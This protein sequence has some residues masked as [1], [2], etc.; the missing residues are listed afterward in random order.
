MLLWNGENNQ[1]FRLQ[2]AADESNVV[3][4]PRGGFQAEPPAQDK[5]GFVYAKHSNSTLQFWTWDDFAGAE[6]GKKRFRLVGNTT[7]DG[8]AF[9]LQSIYTGKWVGGSANK[10]TCVNAAKDTLLF[11]LRLAQTEVERERRLLA[12]FQWV[13]RPEDVRAGRAARSGCDWGYS[14]DGG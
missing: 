13:N 3:I 9:G 4:R 14:T 1:Q 6:D 8:L 5:Q 2:I 10:L 7:P 11:S 12:F